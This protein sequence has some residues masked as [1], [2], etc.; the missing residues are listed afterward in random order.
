MTAPLAT[1]LATAERCQ[2]P[3]TPGLL[4]V[5]PAYNEQGRIGAVVDRLHELPLPVLVVDD[6]SRDHTADE[7]EAAGAAVL[8]QRNGGKGAAIL[9]GCRYAV[10]HGYRGV[11][12]LDGDGQ[13]DPRESLRLIA[14]WRR[15]AD[16]VIG[17]RVIGVER[18][19]RHRKV[20]N[21]MSSLL[22]T[23]A[24]GRRVAD[25]QSGFRLCD[26]RLLLRLPFS[27]CRYDL[28][29]EMCVLAARAGY[30]IAEVPITVI[31]N[32]KKSGMH[33][34]YDT[35]RFFRAVGISVLRGR[36]DLAVAS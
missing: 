9:A 22:V 4:A 21:R 13:H 2:A 34:F 30:L 19:P 32:D 18:Q 20:S 17:K 24:A 29:T 25:S 6:G 27:G 10:A 8:R 1:T 35:V 23:I 36:G 15:G 7:A 3:F 26:P 16:L 11:L 28:E 33:P 14:A 31:Y 12:L 5:V